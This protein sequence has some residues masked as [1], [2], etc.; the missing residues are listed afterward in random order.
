MEADQIWDKLKNGEPTTG[1]YSETYTEDKKDA[2]NYWLSVTNLR[3]TRVF[4]ENV[5]EEFF[6][7]AVYFND[8]EE[9]MLIDMNNDN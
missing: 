8:Q 6:P 5:K 1:H 4:D 9:E 2:P 7:S 3:E